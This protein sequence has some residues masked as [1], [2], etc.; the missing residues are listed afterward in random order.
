[1][2]G[3]ILLARENSHLNYLILHYIFSSIFY[4]SID[5]SYK[6]TAQIISLS[7]ILYLL[8]ISLHYLARLHLIIYFYQRALM[9]DKG[10]GTDPEAEK[11]TK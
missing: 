9:D 1:M 6:M 2:R 8:K 3:L 7:F 11:G 5:Y 10:Y 4:I